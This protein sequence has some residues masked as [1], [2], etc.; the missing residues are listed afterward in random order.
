MRHTRVIST[1]PKSVVYYCDITGK[2][3]TENK[4]IMGPV[5]LSEEGAG[6]LPPDMRTRLVVGAVM[7]VFKDPTADTLKVLWTG[8]W[9]LIAGENDTRLVRSWSPNEVGLLPHVTVF[10]YRDGKHIKTYETRPTLK[11]EDY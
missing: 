2:K 10:H 1:V 9:F 11:W 7:E 3:I 6:W 4:I 5:V 8:D